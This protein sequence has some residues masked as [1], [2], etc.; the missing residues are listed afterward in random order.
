MTEVRS[1]SVNDVNYGVTINGEAK[2]GT[3]LLLHGMPDTGAI[4]ARL[5]TN[6]IALGY[7]VVT[8]DM[9]GFGATDKPADA[10]RYAGGK[11]IAD[12]VELIGQLELPKCHIVGHDW[13]AYAGWELVTHLPEQ[14][15]R[16]VAISMSHPAVFFNDLGLRGLRDNW[17]M[18]LNTQEEA[19]DLYRLDNCAFYK[20]FCIPTHPDKEEVCT[21]LT[22]PEAMRGCLNWD[23][24]NPLAA[25][26]LAT[27]KG[28]LEYSKINVP[29]LGIWSA[30]D[31]YLLEEHMQASGDYL[32]AEWSYVRL[33]SGSHWCM[34]DNPEETNR[35]VIDWLE[36]S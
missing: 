21:R 31:T 22:D 20:E 6:L 9:L 16:H 29:T 10:R 32:D 36:R 23:R 2:R 15:D 5:T 8:P 17:Y 19:V 1:V 7:R 11:I 25:S 26:Y 28:E 27:R 13:G 18:Y 12:L 3:V 34:L 4:W 24:G 14:F 35:A 30:G 33:S